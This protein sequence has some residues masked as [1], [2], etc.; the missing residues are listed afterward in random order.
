MLLLLFLFPCTISG[1]VP[2]FNLQTG[3]RG[4]QRDIPEFV[5]VDWTRSKRGGTVS[6]LLALNC[7]FSVLCDYSTLGYMLYSSH[8]L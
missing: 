4:V 3:G 7:L 2:E 5:G 8:I 1:P 6:D